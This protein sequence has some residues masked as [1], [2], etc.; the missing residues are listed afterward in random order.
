MLF[1]PA[2]GVVSVRKSSIPIEA[3][4]VRTRMYPE[5]PLPATGC[6]AFIAPTGEAPPFWGLR[7]SFSD[8]TLV[9]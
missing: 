8:R 9:R 7:E 4:E 3:L 5:L 2:R 6:L 1:L